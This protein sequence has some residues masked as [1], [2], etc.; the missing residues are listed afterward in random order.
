MIRAF[1]P[2]VLIFDI[3]IGAIN[4]LDLLEQVKAEADLAHLPAIVF[5]N[6]DSDEE[7]D[8]AAA[9]G[10]QEYLVKAT[11]DLSDLSR[12]IQRLAAK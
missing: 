5:S 1:K 12:L 11:T 3:M 8:R 2:D 10:A 7:R 4:G 9:L 6:Q